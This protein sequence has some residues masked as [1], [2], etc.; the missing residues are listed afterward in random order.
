MVP[1]PSRR[2]FLAAAG[3]GLTATTAGCSRLEDGSGGATLHRTWLPETDERV[4]VFGWNVDAVR[5]HESHLDW[6]TYKRLTRIKP[7]LPAVATPDVSEAIQRRP[8][9]HLVSRGDYGDV[10]ADLED[11]ENWTNGHDIG[12]FAVR[13]EAHRTRSVATD[14]EVLTT[15]YEDAP[16]DRVETLRRLV[17]TGTGDR[18]S[19]RETMD[20]YDA[21][22]EHI[23]GD[24]V[25]A[26][27]FPEPLSDS[28]VTAY[29]KTTSF[30]GET[31]TL[32]VVTSF[33][34]AVDADVE[35]AKRV[36]DGAY[37]ETTDWDFETIDDRVVATASVRTSAL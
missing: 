12:D 14:G 19:A 4:T 16:E 7:A 1:K 24:G 18:P 31:S 23:A 37:A 34:S 20:S 30:E 11:R 13:H 32:R 29:A 35:S 9:R 28:Q 26:I 17:Q 10:T 27:A 33:S 36:T 21:I 8:L 3:V 6:E 5:D 25:S 15:A 22:L 2:A